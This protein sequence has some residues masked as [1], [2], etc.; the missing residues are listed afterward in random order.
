M[1]YC[2]YFCFLLCVCVY[3]IGSNFRGTKISLKVFFKKLIGFSCLFVRETPE[4]WR[5]HVT[6]A[7]V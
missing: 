3:R 7:I 5:M 2:N 4:D 1:I 6:Q